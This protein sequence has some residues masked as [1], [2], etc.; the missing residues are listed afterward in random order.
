MSGFDDNDGG[1][2][3]TK[4]IG[5]QDI[6]N[7]DKKSSRSAYLIVIS[8]RSVG[9]MYKLS[10][11]S[12][13]TS[14]G[15]TPDADVF[16]DDEGVSRRHAK[17]TNA[18]GV[19]RLVDLGSTNGTFANGQRVSSRVLSDG[20]RLQIGSTTILKFSY[21]DDIEEQF[22]KQLYDSATRDGLTGCFNKKHFAERLRNEFAFATRHDTYLTLVLFDIDLFKKVNDTYG[23]LAGDEVLKR[24]AA[25]VRKQLRTEDTYARY[26]GEEFA[27]ILRETD[28]ERGFIIAERV[29]RAVEAERFEFDAQHIPVTISLGVATLHGDN[30]PSVR[31]MVKIADEFLYRAKR[32]GRNRTEC[33]LLS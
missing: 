31:E 28:D 5:L 11:S 21:Q 22:Q 6:L 7:E 27:I 4:I 18:G 26:G 8:G 29:R 1:G 2:E 30:Y 24:L 19:V 23:H 9:R 15:R 25:V 16:I 33:K 3:H 17:I 10:S 12:P 32:G 13:E 14:I 20:D